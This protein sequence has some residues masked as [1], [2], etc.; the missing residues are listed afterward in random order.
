MVAAL[1]KGLALGILLAISVGPVIFAIIKQ[2][3]NHGHKA[4]YVFVAGV[5]SSDITLLLVCNFFTSLFDTALKHQT[6]I[7]VTGSLFLIGVGIYTFFF[8]KV[9]VDEENNLKEKIFRKRDW[10][11]TF[12]SGYFMNMLNPGVFIFWFAWSAA[13]LAD[14]V[15]YSNPLQYRAVVFGTCLIFVLA[16][17]LLKVALAGKLR[18]K[19]TVK[20]LHNINRLSGLILIGFGVALC[21]GVLSF[22]AR[23]K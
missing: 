7:A 18:P 19:L 20:N 5:S 11:A 3:I 10:V 12:L 6:L 22:G 9:V 13:I 1:I 2:S 16:T 8:K 4:G 21:W 23:L 14:S 17:D 15:S